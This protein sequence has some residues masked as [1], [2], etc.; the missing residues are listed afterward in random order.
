ML[1]DAGAVQLAVYDVHGRQVIQLQ[2]G[3]LPS[4]AHTISWNAD[5]QSSGIYIVRL[6]AEGGEVT[7]KILL[8][9]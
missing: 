7:Q 3:L 2:Q 9:K 4:G 8:L 5:Q 6:Q 1:P